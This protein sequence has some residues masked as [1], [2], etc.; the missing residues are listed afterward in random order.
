MFLR[1]IVGAMAL[2]LAAEV[3]SLIGMALVIASAVRRSMLMKKN[4]AERLLPFIQ[5]SKEVAQSLRPEWQKLRR[6]STQVVTILGTRFRV[7]QAA[8]QDANRRA[9]RM[10]M[11]LGRDRVVTVEQLQHDRDLVSRGILKPVRTAANVALGVRGAT[12]LLRKV[13]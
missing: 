6:D 8:W 7:I 1:I 9:E 5:L 13:A 4:L 3:F 2:A 10:R 11:R 12:W